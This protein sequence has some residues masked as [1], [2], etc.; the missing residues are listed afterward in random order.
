MKPS[1]TAPQA[2][3]KLQGGDVVVPPAIMA[4][5]DSVPPLPGRYVNPPSAVVRGVS[6][7]AV[8]GRG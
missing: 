3:G 4:T 2:A 6:G 8:S 7:V 1:H 5:D